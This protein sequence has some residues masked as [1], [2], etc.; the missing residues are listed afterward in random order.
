VTDVA[1]YWRKNQCSPTVSGQSCC[2]HCPR[3]VRTTR[4]LS[5]GSVTLRSVKCTSAVWNHA[6]GELAQE[7]ESLMFAEPLLS[8]GLAAGPPLRGGSCS[9][10]TGKNAR[11]ISHVRDYHY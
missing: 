3:A 2:P 1:K 4:Y 6:A 9:D 5:I 7:G 11:K 8:A 10:M